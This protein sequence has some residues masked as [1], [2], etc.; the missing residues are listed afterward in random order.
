MAAAHAT[1]VAALLLEANPKLSPNLLK[2]ILLVT[3]IK[4]TSPHAFEQGAG[5]VN[6]ETAYQ[7]A[8]NLDIKKRKL[9]N[10]VS[11]SWTL[12]GEEIWA[13]GAFAV[14]DGLIFTE[15]ATPSYELWGNGLVW[16]ERLL[17]SDS[18]WGC[19]PLRPQQHHLGRRH[20]LG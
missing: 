16:A 20:H 7:L 1:G 2:T 14:A 18:Y 4:L 12:D 3:A 13:G 17:S 10:K 19:R 6:A 15:L 9:K 5:L 8:R 11:A